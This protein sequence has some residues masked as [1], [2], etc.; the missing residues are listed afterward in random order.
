MTPGDENILK[1]LNLLVLLSR[2][3]KQPVSALPEEKQGTLILR[4]EH[5]KMSG[6]FLPAFINTLKIL[7]DRGYLVFVALFEN[8]SRQKIDEIRCQ[9]PFISR[10]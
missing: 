9:E 10:R 7:S 1:V 8:E 5:V 6:L 2:A 4:E 3:Q